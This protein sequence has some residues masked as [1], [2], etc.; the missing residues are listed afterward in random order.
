MVVTSGLYLFFFNYHHLSPFLPKNHRNNG[1]VRSPPLQMLDPQLILSFQWRYRSHWP[2]RHGM[3]KHYRVRRN[4][5]V[6]TVLQGQNLILN[7]NDKGFN[8]V[9]FNRTTSKVDHFLE[10][11]AKG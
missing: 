5:A 1:N 11:E 7:M 6:D 3:S 9:A 8:V 2:R 4:S 10:N